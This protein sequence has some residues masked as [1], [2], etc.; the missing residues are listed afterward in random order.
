[1]M[2][3]IKRHGGE[4][5]GRYNVGLV[6]E[7]NYQQAIQRL[8]IGD[9]VELIR[10]PENQYDP[11]AVKACDVAGRT[12][13]YV[14][15]GSWL[16]RLIAEEDQP[17]VAHV[18]NVTGG[19]R[20]K[21]YRGVVLDIMT[22]NDARTA[23]EGLPPAATTEAPE[24]ISVD[25]APAPYVYEPKNLFDS[26]YDEWFGSGAQE[27]RDKAASTLSVRTGPNS[28]QSCMGCL[29]WTV[30]LVMILMLIGRITADNAL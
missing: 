28:F 20:G 1:M 12:I 2:P 23:R 26:L 13:G 19:E 7:A 6:G 24:A 30:G 16:Q 5:M 25:E 8:R 22:A 14:A 9:P 10:E 4:L 27:R 15:R 29:C 21:P 11:L 3:A 17:V 18:A